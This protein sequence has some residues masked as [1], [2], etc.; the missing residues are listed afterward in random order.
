[1][2]LSGSEVRTRS[3]IFPEGIK[4]A[5][6]THCDNPREVNILKNNLSTVDKED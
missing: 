2:T 5:S 3:N 6:L 1:M 4:V